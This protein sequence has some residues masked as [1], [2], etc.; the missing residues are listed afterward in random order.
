M[1]GG[2]LSAQEGVARSRGT[3]CA[4]AVRAGI[5]C[6][7]AAF[8]ATGDGDLAVK[9]LL[10]LA[11]SAAGRLVSPPP[12]FDLIFS[13][14][15]AVE[16]AGTALGVFGVIVWNDTPSHIVL[17]LLS[18]PILYAALLRLA[19]LERPVQAALCTAGAVLVLG[20]VWE[21]VE[22]VAD[23]VLATDFSQGREDTLGDLINDA[24]AAAAG[25]A[26]V[27]G[28]LHWSGRTA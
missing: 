16:L 3:V 20:L 24:V 5:A 23:L 13:L 26:L 18:A 25:G 6:A 28:W 7:A 22:W 4:D 2:A 21:L 15:L 9:A 27:G 14:A 8:L 1:G 10:L 19:P 11:A 17:P 12:A